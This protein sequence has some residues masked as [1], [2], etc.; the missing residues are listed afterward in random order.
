MRRLSFAA[1]LML[2]PLFVGCGGDDGGATGP[3][4]TE[5]TFDL[6]FTGDDT[7]HGAHG[8]QTIHVGV[9]EQGSG[10]LVT[11][12]QGTVSSSADPSFEFTFTGALTEGDSYYL[13]YWIDSNFSGGMEGS[14]GPPEDDH[15]WRIPVP[16]V[17][18]DVTIDDT[19]RPSETEDVCGSSG[20]SGSDPGY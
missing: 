5:A 16:S 20:D 7:F 15:Q 8:G 2:M 14:C 13:D 18:A 1:A 12:D 19:H 4:E 17:S 3:E 10:A 11:S 9:K 6:T